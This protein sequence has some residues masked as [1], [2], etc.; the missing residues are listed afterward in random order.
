MIDM[1]QGLEALDDAIRS[2]LIPL[3]KV[4]SGRMFPELTVVFDEPDGYLRISYAFIKGRQVRAYAMFLSTEPMDGVP[5]FQLGYAVRPEY[6]G[7]GLGSEIVR[8]AIEELYSG[9]KGSMP[10]F[11]IE[12]VVD[13]NNFVSQR[14][15]EK[16]LSEDAIEV[17]DGYSGEPAIAY[18]RFMEA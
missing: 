7:H 10:A 11:Y 14:I 16:H 3:N 8:K 1:M 15:A 9:L 17:S 18:I 4:E 13:R 2:N 5:C 12:A 6:R